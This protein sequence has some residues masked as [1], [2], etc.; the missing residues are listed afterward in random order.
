MV[1]IILA[2]HVLS[3]IAIVVLVLLQQGK[4]ADMG[5]AFG[6]SQTVFGAAGS[7]NFLSRSTAL[8]ATVFFCTSL[9]L[10]YIYGQ[11]SEPQS[12]TQQVSG[13]SQSKQQEQ[14]SPTT[15]QA[16]SGGQSS[17]ASPAQSDIPAAPDVK[18][19]SGDQGSGGTMKQ[20]TTS[21]G[22]S[23]Q[24][25]TKGETKNGTSE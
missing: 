18:Q 22:T 20:G 10:A 5:A 4:G 2:V 9:S 21:Q 23:G 15:S 7:A 1:N 12:V 17:G 19:G 25:S 6:S 24:G 16:G 14:S 3:A 8:L 13:Q 11:K